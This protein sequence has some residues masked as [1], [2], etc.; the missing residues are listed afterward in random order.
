MSLFCF[1]FVQVLSA[2]TAH[3]VCVCCVLC[4]APRRLMRMK[5]RRGSQAGI[6]EKPG[7]V[8]GFFFVM[9]ILQNLG[10]SW[11]FS[12]LMIVFFC[13]LVRYSVGIGIC[14]FCPCICLTRK[15]GRNKHNYRTSLWGKNCIIQK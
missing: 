15:L 12:I 10:L 9:V 11:D 6:P 5:S 1:L 14:C 8:M 2:V 3:Y 7:I 13:V 4:G